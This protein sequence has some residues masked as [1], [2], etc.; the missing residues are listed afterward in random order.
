ML[1]EYHIHEM[2]R[3]S[4]RSLRNALKFGT[5]V[6]VNS[7]EGR[8]HEEGLM[9]VPTNRSE[10]GSPEVDLNGAVGEALVL[11][12]PPQRLRTKLLFD[13]RI[14]DQFLD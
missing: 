13:V 7:Q 12:P 2:A 8:A 9:V 6:E 5:T 10:I 14:D 4:E 1:A 11:Q 3:L